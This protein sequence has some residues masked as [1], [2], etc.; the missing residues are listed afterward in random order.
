MA[1]KEAVLSNNKLYVVNFNINKVYQYNASDYRK[2]SA[3]Y[4][5]GNKPIGVLEA[6]DKLFVT[7]YDD[8]TVSVIKVK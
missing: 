8:N 7:N 6:N 3:E 2:E 5:T 1:P 4:E